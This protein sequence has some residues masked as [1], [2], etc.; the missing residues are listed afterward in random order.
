MKT[1]LKAVLALFIIPGAGLYAQDFTGQDF[2]EALD[3]A[4]QGTSSVT[5]PKPVLEETPVAFP[6]DNAAASREKEWTIMVFVNG[7]NNLEGDGLADINE[8]EKIGSTRGVNIIVELGQMSDNSMARYYITKDRKPEKI[9]SRRLGSASGVD[10]G[11][12]AAVKDFALWA[13]RRFPAKKYM[14]ILWDHGSGWLKGNPVEEPSSSKGISDDWITGHNIDTPQLG[15]LVRDIEAGGGRVDLLAMDACLMQMVEVAY[16]M[17]D[18]KVSHIAASEEIEPGSG[19]PY[20]KWLAPLALRPSMT[21]AQLGTIVAQEYLKANP[22]GF[23]GIGLTYSVLEVA[24]VPQLAVKLD[25]LAKAAMAAN[26]KAAVLRAR[27]EATRYS[28]GDNKD[29]RRFAQ[30]LMQHSANA[31]VKTAAAEVE[32]LMA[33]TEGPVI[34]TG[35]SANRPTLS[36]GAAVYLPENADDISGYSELKMSADTQWDEFVKWILEP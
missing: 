23:Q 1:A 15:R 7:K 27:A 11:D 29:L 19:Y 30:L 36:H 28:L 32:R 2:R 34:F 13:Q 35:V 9:T 10:M 20:D 18:T 17:K 25:A 4:R 16:E 22:Y 3:N 26:D 31:E 5:L 21:A 8:M 33:G 14:L 24:K 12:P 6:E